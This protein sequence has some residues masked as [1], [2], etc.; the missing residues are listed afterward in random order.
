MD[1]LEVEEDKVG[2]GLQF[3]SA[4]PVD[5]PV[6]WLDDSPKPSPMKWLAETSP[7]PG[8]APGSPAATS[9]AAAS[10]VAETS[11]DDEGMPNVISEFYSVHGAAEII[12]RNLQLQAQYGPY[13]GGE[14]NI[15]EFS[16]EGAASSRPDGL[17][18]TI[19]NSIPSTI[20]NSIPSTVINS[21]VEEQHPT[22]RCQNVTLY[23]ERSTSLSWGEGLDPPAEVALPGAYS[24]PGWLETE[25]SRGYPT[26]TYLLYPLHYSYVDSFLKLPITQNKVR[27]L[28]RY[29]YSHEERVKIW[30]ILRSG[31]E[32][33]LT[34][35]G[36]EIILGGSFFNHYNMQIIIKYY[37]APGHTIRLDVH[38][39][40]NFL[41]IRVPTKYMDTTGPI[42]GPLEIKG[43]ETPNWFVRPAESTTTRPLFIRVRS[44]ASL[45]G[46]SP[47]LRRILNTPL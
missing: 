47:L 43:P 12:E 41:G 46:E 7:P 23:S 2:L 11:G 34:I 45:K 29:L 20:I 33:N 31:G 35:P 38:N 14:F 25:M 5:L 3:L 21:N 18:S 28:V 22:E 40:K 4:V 1:K 6:D 39:H 13:F 9:T 37:P 16:G 44:E 26:R 17:P 8:Q 10:T 32:W 15:A 36:C 30:W 42:I 24:I 27:W 19:I